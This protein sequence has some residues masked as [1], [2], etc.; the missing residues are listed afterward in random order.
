M[1]KNIKNCSTCVH[2][3]DPIGNK[4][5][6]DCIHGS[7]RFALWEPDIGITWQDKKDK[8]EILKPQQTNLFE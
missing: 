6:C 5:C 7:P 3:S 4:R 1:I 2:L 8:P